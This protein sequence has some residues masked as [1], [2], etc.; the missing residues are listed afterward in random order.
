[1]HI[2]RVVTSVVFTPTSRG[3]WCLNQR[4]RARRWATRGRALRVDGRQCWRAHLVARHFRDGLTRAVVN[5]APMAVVKWCYTILRSGASWRGGAV[6]RVRECMLRRL[7]S[8]LRHAGSCKRLASP[9]TPS[10]SRP[11]FSSDTK[12]PLLRHD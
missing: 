9:M 5:N 8:K 4:R 1:V 6:A 12:A 7:S 3:S 10:P 2:E 11:I